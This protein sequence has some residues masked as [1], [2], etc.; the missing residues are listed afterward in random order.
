MTNECGAVGAL[1]GAER[2]RWAV[3][4]RYFGL[5]LFPREQPLL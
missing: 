2:K 1:E 5:A 4:V 3:R